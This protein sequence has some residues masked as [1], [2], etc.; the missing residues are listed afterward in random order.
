MFM[1]TPDFAVASLRALVRRQAGE[2]TVI[3]QPDKP[4]GR[5]MILT[6]PEVKVYAESVGLPV[7]Q[8][9]TL[10]DEEFDAF[11]SEKDPDIIIVAAYGKI[12]P[13]SVIDY[14]KYGCINV[15]G[16]LLP[17]YRGAAPVQRCLIN[18]ETKT[19]N[20]IMYMDEG[21]DTGD[22]IAQSIVPISIDDNAETLFEKMALDGAELLMS[23]LPN[24]VSGNIV[25][26]KQSD[27]DATYA[28]KVV[29]EDCM[30]DFSMTAEEIHNRVRGLSP[31]LYAY[32][33]RGQTQLKLVKTALVDRR[34]NYLGGTLVLD[35]N[36]LYVACQGGWLLEILEVLPAGKKQMKATDYLRGNPV[37]DG[38]RLIPV[39]SKLCFG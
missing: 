27:A 3:T 30:I 19:G 37:K 1:G 29:K 16:S 20:T 23:V 11:L 18:G 32:A 39:R 35:G 13:K 14:P 33:M 2:I 12:L 15:H 25:R 38:E 28:Q 4:K 7:Y 24:I 34:T 31:Y 22:I 26:K 10:R 36:K 5:K 8:P 9:K 17:K 21:L 6:P